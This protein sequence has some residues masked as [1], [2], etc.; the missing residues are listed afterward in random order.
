MASKPCLAEALTVKPRPGVPRAED[1]RCNPASAPAICMQKQSLSKSQH[2]TEVSWRGHDRPHQTLNHR[3]QNKDW[4]SGCGSG[5][6]RGGTGPSPHVNTCIHMHTHAYI[7]VRTIRIG[8]TRLP[9]LACARTHEII[10]RSPYTCSKSA[11]T[12]RH[13]HARTHTHTHTHTCITVCFHASSSCSLYSCMQ[14]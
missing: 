3:F 13:T 11:L 4:G 9:L 2:C 14:V 12:A 6:G 5:S 7:H 8:Y 1:L 10:R